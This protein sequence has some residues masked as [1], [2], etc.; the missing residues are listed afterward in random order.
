M[1]FTTA[2]PFTRAEALAAKI[3]VKELAGPE[4]RRI[5]HGIYLDRRVPLDIRHRAMAALH[6]APPGSYASHHTAAQLWGGVAPATTDTHLSAPTP[7][8]RSI[9]RG[10]VAHRIQFDAAP[11]S[12]H[13][14]LVSSPE[15]TFLELASARVGLIDL[16]VLGDSLVRRELTTPEKLIKAA[17]DWTGRGSRVARR[18]ARFVRTGVDSP[19]E[20]RVRLLIVLAGFPEP[21][22][23]LIIRYPDGSWRW[24]F[25]ICYPAYMVIIEYDGRHHADDPG[26]WNADILRREELERAGW[27][28]V[29]VTARAFYTEPAAVLARISETLGSRG[30]DLPRRKVPAEWARLFPGRAATAV[31][32]STGG[33]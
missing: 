8:T 29:V 9:R 21:V 16:V 4:Y 27:R 15:Q 32:S 19:M 25:E 24:R 23:N 2:R 28:S 20:T 30:A 22:V 10:I 7:L 14:I 31:E 13:G 26:Q 1:T 11:R 18:A 12:R 6:I 5:F 33:R 17:A 3:S